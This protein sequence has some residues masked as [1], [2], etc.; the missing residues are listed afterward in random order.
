MYDKML[1]RVDREVVVA[2][3]WYIMD[4]CHCPQEHLLWFCVCEGNSPLF[5]SYSFTTTS[6]GMRLNLKQCY[7]WVS[8]CSLIRKRAT[9]TRSCPGRLL[10]LFL[11]GFL[12]YQL[13]H[14]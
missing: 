10:D 12:S 2:L 13:D 7:L 4:N 11:D 6:S 1:R 14:I 3:A 9:S 8:S 5:R